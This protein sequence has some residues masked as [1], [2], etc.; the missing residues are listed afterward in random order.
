MTDHPMPDAVLAELAAALDAALT[1]LGAASSLDELDAVRRRVGTLD[2][3]E[4]PAVGAEVE[5]AV[6]AVTRALAAKEEALLDSQ[7][8]LEYPVDIT[9]PGT[10]ARTGGLHPTTRMRYDLDD[11]F[12][13]LNFEL[14]SGPEIS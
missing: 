6:E 2:P 12:A 1:E 14:Y 11:A 4:R 10:P 9:L 8:S 13:A 5:A 3:S 7:P